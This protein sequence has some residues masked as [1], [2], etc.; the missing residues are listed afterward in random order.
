MPHHHPSCHE[1]WPERWCWTAASVSPDT[2]G[3]ETETVTKKEEVIL[4]AKHRAERKRDEPT[5]A[6]IEY[7]LRIHEELKLLQAQ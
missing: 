3:W 4:N 1:A 2:G 6:G 5:R 7:Q